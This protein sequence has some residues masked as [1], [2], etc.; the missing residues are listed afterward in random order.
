MFQLKVL[1]TYN[2][3]INYNNADLTPSQ[4]SQLQFSWIS[5]CSLYCSSISALTT[6]KLIHINA[7]VTMEFHYNLSSW[8]RTA[9]FIL[10]PKLFLEDLTTSILSVSLHS[11]LSRAIIIHT[12]SLH[13]PLFSSTL[14]QYCTFILFQSLVGL[15]NAV[16]KIY[17]VEIDVDDDF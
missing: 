16:D 8:N 6:T 14:N 9:S 15:F 7:F 11:A 4:S 12:S 2:N 1:I 13:P 5:L 3:Q 17:M 10:N